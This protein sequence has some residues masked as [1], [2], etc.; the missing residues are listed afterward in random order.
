MQRLKE[1]REQRGLTQAKLAEQLGTT[2][3]T[4]HKYEHGTAEPEHK[5]LRRISDFFNVSAD[6]LIDHE[7]HDLTLDAQEQHLIHTL[8]TL[9]APDKTILFNAADSFAQKE[10]PTTSDERSVIDHYRKLEPFQKRL[11]NREIDKM[12][13]ENSKK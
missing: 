9:D 12:L 2:Q 5:M 10:Y 6:Y 11:I 4:I 7:V 3:Q 13:A 8:R 1:L